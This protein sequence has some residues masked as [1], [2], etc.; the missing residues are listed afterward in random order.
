MEEMTSKVG[1]DESEDST[2]RVCDLGG[3]SLRKK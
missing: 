1:L 2:G 3:Q